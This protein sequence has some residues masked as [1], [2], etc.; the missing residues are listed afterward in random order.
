L[1]FRWDEAGSVTWTDIQFR[2][3]KAPG[4]RNVVLATVNHRP[5][6]TSG[7]EESLKSFCRFLEIAGEKG[8]DIVCLPEGATVIGT[9]KDYL[10]VAEPIPGPSTKILGELARHHS[11][12]IVA[13]LYEQD[14]D[15]F[16][17]V[18]VLIDRE[19]NVAGLYRKVSLPRGEI[20]A[21]LTPGREF[22]V[23]ETDFGKVG[24]MICWDSQFPEASRR[25]AAAGAEVIMLPIWGGSETLFAARAIENDVHL[26]TSSFDSKSGIWNRKGKLIAEAQNE[27]S[28]ALVEVDLSEAVFQQWIG[29]LRAH[30]PRE[31]PPVKEQ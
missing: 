17:N 6:E 29:D 21:G 24:M 8:A 19:G 2:P 23:F 25:L 11:M 5:R 1:I 28:V 3:T 30:I 4:S 14:G 12:Y 15:T 27:G 26:V 18:S 22:P 16:Y 9:G 7:P 31:S 13:G 20:D 10:A